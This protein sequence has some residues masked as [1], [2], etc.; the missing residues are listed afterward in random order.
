MSSKNKDTRTQI[1][2]TTWQL[3]EKGHGQGVRMS[4]I[5][6]AVGI[7]RQAVYLHFSNR[8]ELLIATT[9][10][11]D[12]VKGLQERLS[13]LQKASNGID[14]LNKCVDVW[15]NYIPEIY[16]IA[17]ALLI[18]RETDE[19]ANA[20]W[21]DVMGCL[22]VAC[23]EIISVLEKEKILAPE[24]SKNEAIEMLWTQLSIQNWEILIT[25]SDW[26][27]EQYIVAMKRLLIRTFIK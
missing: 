26:T 4:D 10:Y 13:Q 22:K 16:G 18:T 1:L 17:K 15:G 24:W 2:E 21:N 6:K 27:T 9:H 20:A 14:L 19:A 23:Q 8:T 12:E 3:L 11:V 5:A 25:D 7:S